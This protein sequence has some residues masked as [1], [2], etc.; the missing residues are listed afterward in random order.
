LLNS[1]VRWMEWGF[2]QRSTLP[3][4]AEEPDVNQGRRFGRHRQLRSKTPQATSLKPR[5]LQ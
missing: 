5:P 1:G 4:E 3:F 2:C